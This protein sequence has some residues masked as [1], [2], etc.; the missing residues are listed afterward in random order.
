MALSTGPRSTVLAHWLLALVAM[1]AGG[2]ELS[3][4]PV[5]VGIDRDFPPYE[6][7]DESGAPSGFDVELARQV[8]S[9]AGIQ[10]VFE[11]SHGS[12]LVASLEAGRFQA[13]AGTFHFESL[14]RT[15]A[16]SAPHVGVEF[17]I[18]GRT[19]ANELSGLAE[20]KGK[21]VLVNRGDAM[22]EWLRGRGVPFRIVA[23]DSADD[24]L[25]RLAAGQGDYAVMAR[26]EGALIAGRLKLGNVVALPV[27]VALRPYCFAVRRGDARL[28][29]DLNRG[30]AEVRKSGEYERLNRKWFALLQP[31][32]GTLVWIFRHGAFFVVPLLLVLVAVV[33]WSRTLARRVD[34][35]TRLLREELAERQRAEEALRESELRFRALAENVPFAILIV[36]DECIVYANRS[37]EEIHGYSA[38]ELLGTSPWR[39]I[40]PDSLPTVKERSARRLAG[41]SGIPSHYE[42]KISKKDGSERWVESSAA[43]TTHAGR[44]AIVLALSDVTDRRRTQETQ[45]AIY[46]I[47]EAA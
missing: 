31:Q 9:A 14:D 1:T 7:V 46:E 41:E 35:R 19:G 4:P 23:A 34:S 5:V 30:L 21:E 32:R 33:T 22:G 42:L 37:A 39:L 20:L 17:A 29:A 11:A 3:R 25:R 36:Q 2:T 18:F 44:P 45:A 8:A 24:T 13:L 38:Y 10:V 27:P 16:F 28:L 43:T 40:H 15:L 12:D 6:F 47:S 26:S